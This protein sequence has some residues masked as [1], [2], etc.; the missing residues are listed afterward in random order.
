MKKHSGMRPQ[1]IVVLLKIV[2]KGNEQ[3]YMK[4][5]AN[6][7]SI[8]A[9]E[10]T[11]SISRS[12]LAGLISSNKKTI[13]RLALLDFLEHGIK[14]V[15]PQRPGAISQGMA[16]A[17]SAEPLVDLLVNDEPYVWPYAKGNTRGQS[18]EPLYPSVVEA[19]LKDKELYELLA[20]VDALR[21]GKAREKQIAMNELKKRIAN[22]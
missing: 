21:V 3:W 10:V 19:S 14:Y 11:E 16:T 18:I 13:F 4:D 20:L 22:A 9:S 6:E 15:F 8:S 12:V 17:H 2:A 1:D 7:L 5:L